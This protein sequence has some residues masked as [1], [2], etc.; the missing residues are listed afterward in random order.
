[1]SM[2]TIKTADLIGPALDW[3]VGLV[4]GGKPIVCGGSLPRWKFTALEASVWVGDKELGDIERY[5]P[6]TVWGDGGPVLDRLMKSGK[7]ELVQWEPGKEVALQNFDSECLPVDGISYDDRSI[8]ESG[9]TVLIAAC[10]AYVASEIG[11]E[12]QVPA[13]L[14][15]P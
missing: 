9:A 11:D 5:S 10:R 14:V 6:S 7:W 8:H 1:M 2:V 13:E 15:Q 4:V 3:A 12:V